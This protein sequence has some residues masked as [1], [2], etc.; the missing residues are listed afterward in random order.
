MKKRWITLTVVLLI[1]FAFVVAVDLVA[2]PLLLPRVQSA[3]NESCTHCEL[4]IGSL[5]LGLFPPRAILGGV[6]YRE[7]DPRDSLLV[8]QAKVTVVPLPLSNLRKGPWRV[9]MIRVEGANVL[10]EE[11]SKSLPKPPPSP[12]KNTEI[13]FAGA[14]ILHAEF[15]Y[16]YNAPSGPALI[17]VHEIDAHG[18][19][20]GTGESSKDVAIDATADARLEG[21]GKVSL[22]VSAAFFADTPTCD[23]DLR[24]T[25]QN[26]A[27]MNSYFG[28]ADGVE[29]S[30]K[31]LDA[32]GIAKIRGKRGE[33]DVTASFTGLGVH[34]RPNR[35][36]GGLLAFFENLGAKVKVKGAN[37][38]DPRSAKERQVVTTRH[39]RE[40]VVSMVLRTLKEAALR[41]ASK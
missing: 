18:G 2:G 35:K 41:V 17:R 12:G 36:R 11:G 38:S 26:L 10:V 1:C 14:S 3:V 8:A 34:F 6:T 30:G 22:S 4:Q 15:T 7:G 19:P 33:G 20:F 13:L 28:V 5:D 39:E 23:V 16:H 37:F 9:G 21:S 25:G 29:L 31:L 32:R 40:T 24:L 27:E